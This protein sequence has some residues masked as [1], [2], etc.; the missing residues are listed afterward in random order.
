MSRRRRP[1]HSPED[2]SMREKFPSASLMYGTLGFTDPVNAVTSATPPEGVQSPQG[3]PYR[4]VSSLDAGAAGGL[5]G[6]SQ[7]AYD[8]TRH[9]TNADGAY[10]A[11]INANGPINE[12]TTAFNTY[13]PASGR[14]SGVY[15][16]TG[17]G[18]EGEDRPPSD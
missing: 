8:G 18:D 4:A 17:Y 1:R 13:N 16:R 2:A 7:S 12:A 11:V 15:S 14:V 3:A 6:V 10:N 9:A 5:S